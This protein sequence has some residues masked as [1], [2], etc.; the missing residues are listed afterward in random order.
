MMRNHEAKRPNTKL[1]E[2]RTAILPLYRY[3]GHIC[4]STKDKVERFFMNMT[5]PDETHFTCHSFSRKAKYCSFL[6]KRMVFLQV[7]SLLQT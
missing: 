4:N 3:K 5:I 7:T 1:S 6:A 2:M